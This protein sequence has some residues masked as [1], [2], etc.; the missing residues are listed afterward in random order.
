[1][2]RASTGGPARGDAFWIWAS[3]PRGTARHHI[4]QTAYW[5]A[6]SWLRIGR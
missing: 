3:P 5:L 2:C 4:I 6:A 1:M